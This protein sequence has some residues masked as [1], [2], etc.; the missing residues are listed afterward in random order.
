MISIHTYYNI[1]PST[2][3]LV[4]SLR[5]LAFCSKLRICTPMAVL[6]AVALLFHS[7]AV[8]AQQNNSALP[9]AAS[10]SPRSP[11][12]QLPQTGSSLLG[13]SAQNEEMTA[14]QKQM[15]QQQAEN[16]IRSDAFNA[17]MT[18]LLPLRPEDIRRLLMQYDDV[19]RAIETPV[20]PNPQPE[21][22]FE[23]ISLDPGSTPPLIKLATNHVSTLNVL[24]VTGA[25]W[26]IQDISWAGNFEI[27]QPEEGAH[28]VRIIPLSEFAYGNMS[29][30]LIDLK[31]PI[32]FTLETHRD[33]VQYRFD[34]RIPKPGPQATISLI[35]GGTRLTAGDSLLQTILD[36]VP[37]QDAVKLQVAGVDGR[38]TAYRV[39]E[40]T[41]VRTP[42]TLLSPGWHNSVSSADG[43]NV[44]NLANAP[45]LL[46]S[47][48][49]RVVR[50][51]LT[52]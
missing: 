30:R 24:D 48:Q 49:G 11:G 51:I 2:K 27:T 37:P 40:Q 6:L 18:G 12:L 35:K 14:Q 50:A 8:Q 9:S 1:A 33:S 7:T 52:E 16:Q 44:Y 17:A 21:I 28:V 46:L 47:E 3:R 23:T 25:P 19:Q 4:S 34:A 22:S 10:I 43:M 15:L 26:P 36:G 31:T 5:E 41:F 39:G 45:V 38:T 13:N 20:Y 29:V 32:I 42:L